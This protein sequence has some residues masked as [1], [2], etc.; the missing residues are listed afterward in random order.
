M[1]MTIPIWDSH[2]APTFSYLLLYDPKM[3]SCYA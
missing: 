3:Y 1:N 2:A